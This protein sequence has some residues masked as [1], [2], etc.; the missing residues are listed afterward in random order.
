[1]N[2]T[3]IHRNR[4]ALTAAAALILSLG[5]SVAQAETLEEVIVYGSSAAVRAQQANLDAEMAE[6]VRSVEASIESAQQQ[7]LRRAPAPNLRVAIAGE[8]HRG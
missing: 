6:Y 1:M 2:T 5:A 3:R 4:G 8:L 7:R